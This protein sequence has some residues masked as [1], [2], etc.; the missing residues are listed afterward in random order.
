M[1]Y[2][3]IYTKDDEFTGIVR[4]KH[5]PRVA[6][7]YYRHSIVILRNQEGLYVLQQRSLKARYFPGKW[8]VTGG[9]VRHKE[10]PEETAVREV[11]E[12]L[13]LTIDIQELVFLYKYRVEFEMKD[14]S[15]V[16]VFAAPCDTSTGYVFD[17]YEVN[18]VKI[19]PFEAYFEAVMFNKDE[20][21]ARALK[22]YEMCASLFNSNEN[23]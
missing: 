18:A 23:E 3:D 6:G 22:E 19:I 17:P 10:T 11:K 8:D 5:A 2:R 4:E 7:E 14:G 20:R 9:G 15:I 21:F 13:G 16:Y 12:E 1:E